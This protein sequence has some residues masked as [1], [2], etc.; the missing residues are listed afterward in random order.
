MI[1]GRKNILDRHTVVW[2]FK[3][4]IFNN[5]NLLLKS[6]GTLVAKSPFDS[7]DPQLNRERNLEVGAMNPACKINIKSK[8]NSSNQKL[9]VAYPDR[10]NNRKQLLLI[11]YS[12]SNMN[13]FALYQLQQKILAALSFQR[14]FWG[15]LFL[16]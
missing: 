4:V 13:R 6:F 8:N 9:N 15:R 7:E 16:S 2:F 3:I 5:F 14:C 12:I 10:R 1:A 11:A